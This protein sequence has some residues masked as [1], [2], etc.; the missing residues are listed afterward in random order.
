MLAGLKT[1][2][3]MQIYFRF[4]GSYGSSI[5]IYAT[6]VGLDFVVVVVVLGCF[7]CV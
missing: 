5:N 6:E 2:K 7:G 4:A 3:N 1:Q